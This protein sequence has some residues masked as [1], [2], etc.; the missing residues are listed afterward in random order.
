M[1]RENFEVR[2]LLRYVDLCLCFLMEFEIVSLYRV[3]SLLYSARFFPSTVAPIND[4]NQLP[5]SPN[6]SSLQSMLSTT[7]SLSLSLSLSFCTVWMYGGAANDGT[8]SGN[9]N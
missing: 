3:L 6:D 5:P 9:K 4:S 8:N 1:H 7:L 2:F